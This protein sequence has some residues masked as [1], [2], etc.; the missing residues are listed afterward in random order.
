M[1]AM[2]EN[3]QNRTTRLV[4]ELWRKNQPQILARLAS[5]EEAI[6]AARAGVLSD[7]QR[8]EAE[9]L[10]HKLAGSLGMFG[11]PAGTTI[12][13]SL[14]DEFH[15]DSPDPAVLKALIH[16]LRTTLFPSTD[17]PPTDS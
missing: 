10:S 16:R 8:T 13:R 7:P 14:E 15:L 9:S 11:F 4:A 17:I 12:A 6:E 3:A 2:Q 5:L 1:Q